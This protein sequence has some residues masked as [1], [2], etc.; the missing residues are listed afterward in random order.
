MWYAIFSDQWKLLQTSQLLEERWLETWLDSNQDCFRYFQTS[1]LRSLI[2]FLYFF[3]TKSWITL[4]RKTR[5][6]HHFYSKKI[7]LCQKQFNKSRY[8]WG[9]EV[10]VFQLYNVT[11]S[12]HNNN[13]QKVKLLNTPSTCITR[14]S[15]AVGAEVTCRLICLLQGI[16]K[17]SGFWI[18]ILSTSAKLI[19]NGLPRAVQS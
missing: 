8:E 12:F 13:F 5:V 7:N 17:L 2:V 9:L 6:R 16:N 14:S 11:V 18:L 3:I 19:D 10:K 4:V 1:M 15:M